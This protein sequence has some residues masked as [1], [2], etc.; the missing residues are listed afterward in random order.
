MRLPPS[1]NLAVLTYD[2]DTYAA[3]KQAALD[4]WANHLAVAKANG[5]NV[6]VLRKAESQ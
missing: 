5:A 2:R 1:S 3:E 6:T 4:L